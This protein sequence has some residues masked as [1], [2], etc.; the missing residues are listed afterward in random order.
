MRSTRHAG[1]AIR[2][3][4]GLNIYE[5][6]TDTIIHQRLLDGIGA[7][8]RYTLVNLKRTRA[9]IGCTDYAIAVLAIRVV[10]INHTD[11]GVEVSLLVR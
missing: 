9:L 5:F 6:L 3:D 1:F 8:Q 4:T 11:I 2:N 10:E 7:L